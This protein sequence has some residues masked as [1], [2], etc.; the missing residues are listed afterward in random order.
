MNTAMSNVQMQEQIQAFI[1][2]KFPLSRKRSL[3]PQV[4]LL[5][6]GILD[7]LGILD[8]VSFVEQTFGIVV[9][10]EELVPEN[11]RSIES[12]SAFVLAKGSEAS[13]SE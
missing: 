11:F 7:S 5:E 8:L 3:T 2:E 12:L 13:Q 1:F 10:D 4:D 6:S 9:N